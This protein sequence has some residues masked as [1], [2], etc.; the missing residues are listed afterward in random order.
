MDMQSFSVLPTQQYM[1]NAK[2][3]EFLTVKVYFCCPLLYALATLRVNFGT[4]TRF[5][6]KK[7][8][9]MHK[10]RFSIK[11]RATEI[12]LSILIACSKHLFSIDLKQIG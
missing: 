3:P 5:H 9:S 2:L 11:A 8:K 1:E 10:G 6:K 12:Q 7:K 4:N